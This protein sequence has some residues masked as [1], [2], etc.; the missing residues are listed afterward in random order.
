MIRA[1]WSG[2]LVLEPH[3]PGWETSLGRTDREVQVKRWVL[4]PR[5]LAPPLLAALAFALTIFTGL[6]IRAVPAL[7]AL[8][9]RLYH[10]VN[11][12]AC[13]ATPQDLFYRVMWTGFN[14]TLNNYLAI[15]AI[16]TAY[17]LI[18]KRQEWPKLIVVGLVVAGLGY[19][20]NP[21]IW[22]WAWGPRPWVTTDACIL[23]PQFEPAW[24][25]YSS[26]PSGHARETA[27]EITVLITFWRRIWPLGLLYVA[28]LDFS[29]VYIGVHFPF[30]VATGT[31]LGWAIARIA[32]LAY[33]VYV[34]PWLDRLRGT[35][36]SSRAAGHGDGTTQG[37][38]KW[39]VAHS[40]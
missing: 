23:Y 15:Y 26:F 2:M 19:V 6:T 12:L 35:R 39:T 21:V 40:G 9:T 33:E 18:R 29:R 17:V 13:G 34:A 31:I 11:G 25:G 8:N 37:R 32:F 1:P 3:R 27:A 20:A 30:D 36:T 4:V 5:L 7:E 28:L 22:H 38:S 10:A 16:I 24:S 14:Q